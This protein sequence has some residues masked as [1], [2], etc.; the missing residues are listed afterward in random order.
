VKDTADP[1]SVL[2]SPPTYVRHLVLAA[3]CAITT[4]N[5]MQRNSL[6]AVETQVSADLTVSDV[7]L[8][9]AKGA[10]FW[11]YALCQ[12]PSGWLAQ[13][14]GGR[15]ALTLFAA[16][17]SIVMGLTAIAPN[18]PVLLGARGAMGSLQA[19]IF[20]CC[21]MILAAWYPAARRGFASAV[22]NS[23]MLIGGAVA[24]VLTGLL[25]G[26]LNWRG[27]FALYALP[28]LLWAFWFAKWFRNNPR[29][30]AG[31]N[32]SELSIIGTAPPIAD[33]K[34]MARPSIPWLQILGSSALWLICI[35]QFCRAGAYRF[36]DQTLPTYLQ[37][38]RGQSIQDANL[39]T[40]LPMW[41][42]VIGGMLGGML[43]DWVLTRT[44]SRRAARQGVAIGSLLLCLLCYSV[45]YQFADVRWTMLTAGLGLCVMTFSSPCSYALTMDMGGRNLAV[46][47]ATMNMAGN[48]GAA[49]FTTFISPIAEWG[50]WNAALFVFAAMHVVA[51]LCWLPLNPNGVIG[52]RV[53]AAPD[54]K[55]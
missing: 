44:G 17:W 16:G 31:V 32:A 52:E 13:R 36:F 8:G 27:L 49:A 11:A 18:L 2:S 28:G 39:W 24:S 43:S 40:S 29:D 4:I 14:W 10:F 5:Y 34:S 1:A 50:G 46:I 37:R 9:Y 7:D 21:T 22:L 26:V 54:S 55:E 53:E 42:G 38:A 48:L 19:G 51:L 25:I 33:V 35:Q 20:P 12:I 30:H 3:L 6:A 41:A 23:F 45:A 47:F 15:R